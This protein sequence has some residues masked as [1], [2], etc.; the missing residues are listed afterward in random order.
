VPDLAKLSPRELLVL[1]ANVMEELRAR[2][3]T[4]TS[5]NPTADL[6]EM[7]F[8]KAFGWTQSHNSS[9]NIDAVGADGLRYQIMKR[10][11][12]FGK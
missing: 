9:A 5:N 11:R 2:G 4:R 8:C 10:A 7:L 12:S 6:A 3:V 1:H